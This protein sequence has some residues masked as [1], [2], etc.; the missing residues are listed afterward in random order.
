MSSLV[1]KLIGVGEVADIG[2]CPS[3]K[4][5]A[6]IKEAKISE[7]DLAM[8]RRAYRFTQLSAYVLAL[9][10][11]VLVLLLAS[12]GAWASAGAYLIMSAWSVVMGCCWGYPH[13]QIKYRK[14]VPFLAAIRDPKF[15]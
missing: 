6:F 13:Y 1:S 2:E 11:F 14:L 8:K 3:K 5:E 4:F 10:G 15:L 12:S 9:F 7:P